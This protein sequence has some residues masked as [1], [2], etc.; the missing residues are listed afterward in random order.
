VGVTIATAALA[1][2]GVAAVS[3]VAAPLP[4]KAGAKPAPA[5][6]KPLP[7]PDR[8]ADPQMKAVLVELARLNP[9]PLY[10]LTPEQ[11][12]K[13]PGP[14][15]V[16]KAVLK[17]QGKPT[18]PEPVASVKDTNVPGPAGQIPVRVYTPSGSGPFPVLVYF[19]GGGWVIASI[20]AYD[21]SCRALANAA[22]CVVVSVGYR[23]A[24]EH[25]FPAAHEDSYAATQY[26]MKNTAAEFN[27]DPKRVAVGGES[28]G[29]N[30]AAAV[31]LMAKERGGMMPVHQMNVYP[32]ADNEL[33]KPSYQENATAIPLS[34]PLMA[35]FFK[36]TLKDPKD[37][38][39]P[40]ISLVEADLKGLPPATV[41]TAEIDP[42]RSEGKMYADRLKAAGVPVRYKDYTGVSHE[43]FGMAAVVDKAKDAN[44]FAAQGLK[45]AF[46]RGAAQTASSR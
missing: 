13:R 22:N 36:Y 9:T 43:F 35:W 44:Q 30:L 32:I 40:L 12:R 41:I 16:V 18:T 26:V 1:A 38:E 15:D 3:V 2:L 21:A 33:D 4:P 10:K 25:K 34:K 24:P 23:Q 11:A 7:P 29:G 27:G 37:G 45:A 8:K 14:P 39:S 28:A 5:P 6:A 17:K 42:L 20:Q 31:C 19:H 46:A